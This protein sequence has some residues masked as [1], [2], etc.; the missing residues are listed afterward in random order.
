M[1]YI[2]QLSVPSPQTIGA[3]GKKKYVYDIEIQVPDL[4]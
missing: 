2:Q 3:F 4:Y 1:R